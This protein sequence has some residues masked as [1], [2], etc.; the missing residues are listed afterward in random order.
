MLSGASKMLRRFEKGLNNAKLKFRA[1][2]EY[3]QFVPY[4]TSAA[5]RGIPSDIESNSTT[6]NGRSGSMNVVGSTWL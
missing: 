3:D 6:R 4:C 1:D 5:I 2:E